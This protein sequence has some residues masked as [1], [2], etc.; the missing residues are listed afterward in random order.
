MTYRRKILSKN[1][2]GVMSK[3][4]LSASAEK[5]WLAKTAAALA[6]SGES[7][8]KASASWLAAATWRQPVWTAARQP[9]PPLAQRS[10]GSA[11]WHGGM[12][13]AAA[14]KSNVMLA[15]QWLS[16]A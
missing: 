15:Y 6:R 7:G 2:N 14:P 3:T 10:A 4:W 5:T 8:A 13:L 11:Q 9:S 12:A 1:D 16:M